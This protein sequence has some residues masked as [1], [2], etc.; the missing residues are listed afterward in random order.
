MA[1]TTPAALTV[2][3]LLFREEKPPTPAESALSNGGI[4]NGKQFSIE[5]SR[6]ERTDPPT[7]G[8]QTERATEHRFG[9]PWVPTDYHH[10]SRVVR[11]NDSPA[12]TADEDHQDRRTLRTTDEA[13]FG[14]AA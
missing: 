7:F 14:T 12:L 10:G 3:A 6:R 8:T 13:E 11:A 5:S 2:T 9:Q 1:P 4:G